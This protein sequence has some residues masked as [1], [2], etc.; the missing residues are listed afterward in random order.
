MVVVVVVVVV[1]GSS[2]RSL[3][4]PL[5]QQYCPGMIKFRKKNLIIFSRAKNFKKIP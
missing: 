4:A 2:Q 5:R 3:S 1:V